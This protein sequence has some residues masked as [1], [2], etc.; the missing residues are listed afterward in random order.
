MF[1]QS[2][3]VT[4]RGDRPGRDDEHVEMGSEKKRTAALLAVATFLTLLN[5]VL[6][7]P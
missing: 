1:G 2:A 7:T 4:Q 3:G 6:C 5:A